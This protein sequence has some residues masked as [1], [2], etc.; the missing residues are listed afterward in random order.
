[1][2]EVLKHCYPD[3][4]LDLHELR[5]VLN[6]LEGSSGSYSESSSV[7]QASPSKP[8]PVQ[9]SINRSAENGA[10]QEGVALEEIASLHKDL[11]CMMRDSSSEY[12]YIGADSGISFSA[13]VRSLHPDALV[14]KVDKDIIPGLKTT[15]LP[16]TSLESTP[17]SV[18]HSEIQLPRRDLC[19]QYFI[20]IS[21]RFTACTGYIPLSSFIPDWNVHIRIERRRQPPGFHTLRDFCHGLP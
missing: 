4:K 19:F 7:H 13:A 8:E 1:M 12:R 16:P 15:S 11:G 21:K 18:P 20:D 3:R 17:G 2:T 10:A 6:E 5:A 9:S 14:S